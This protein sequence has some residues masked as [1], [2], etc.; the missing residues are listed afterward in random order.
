MHH[1]DDSFEG[2]VGC[3]FF[4]F[5]GGWILYKMFS[6]PAK[7]SA[8]VVNQAIQ[9]TGKALPRGLTPIGELFEYFMFHLERWTGLDLNISPL[10][11]LSACEVICFP[12]ALSLG[13][14]F[15]HITNEKSGI[16]LLISLG[17]GVVWGFLA[18]VDI[19]GGVGRSTSSPEARL[20]GVSTPTDIFL[21]E[22]V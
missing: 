10:R 9:T 11:I 14:F 22:E 8:P 2:A 16:V 20:D 6:A 4:L 12:I 21:G 5:V 17:I 1:R 18:T 19:A 13:L 3:L 15:E 7:A